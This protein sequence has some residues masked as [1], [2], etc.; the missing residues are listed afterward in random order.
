MQHDTTF[1][2]ITC[3]PGTETYSIYG[4]SALRMKIPSRN[5]RPCHITGECLISTLQ[6]LHSNSPEGMLQYLLDADNFQQIPSDISYMKND[7]FRSQEI[8]LSPVEKK[9]S[10][11]SL[12]TENL[13]PE[14]VK[15]RYDFLLR[16]LCNPDQ[17]YT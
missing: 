16:Q 13:K 17:G 8:N 11:R 15:Y 1:Y 5:S 7:G 4:H 2:L 14:N 9:D 6:I 3:G 12:Y 10:C